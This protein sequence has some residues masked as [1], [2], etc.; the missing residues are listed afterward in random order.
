MEF[1]GMKSWFLDKNFSQNERYVIGLSLI[2]SENDVKIM[3]ETEKAVK[4]K[5]CSDFGNITC[6]IP[7]SCCLS[8]EEAEAEEKER[9]E[10]LQR[11]L[12]Y[13]QMLLD[14]AKEN[15][16]RVRRGMRTETIKR[17]IVEA[18]LSIPNYETAYEL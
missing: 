6:W 7:K 5:F 2:N 12:G 16:L 9:E 11:G 3:S 10:R 17:I 8:R 15:K 18:G 4:V 14:Y 13:N 1:Y